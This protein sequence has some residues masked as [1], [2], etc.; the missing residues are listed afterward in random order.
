MRALLINR[1]S[2]DPWPL[3][4]FLSPHLRVGGC[5]LGRKEAAW[6]PALRGWNQSP[7][8]KPP[9]LHPP[10]CQP[11]PAQLLRSPPTFLPTLTAPC[12]VTWSP[13]PSFIGT[14]WGSCQLLSPPAPQ[15]L[16][17]YAFCTL[18]A[19]ALAQP[20]RPDPGRYAQVRSPAPYDAC[21]GPTGVTLQ[22]RWLCKHRGGPLSRELSGSSSARGEVQTWIPGLLPGREEARVSSGLPS[23]CVQLAPT[24]GLFCPRFPQPRPVHSPDGHV[25]CQ[26]PSQPYS[27]TRA[28]AH[29]QRTHVLPGLPPTPQRRD[30]ARPG[31]QTIPKFY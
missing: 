10:G 15:H 26:P 23:S 1:P 19:S 13:A 8:P 12:P 16:T 29:T 14:L 25:L 2:S 18:N 6:E 17:L 4:S 28:W 3:L 31:L 20:P 7:V 5:G 24:T 30:L 11:G 22:A 9:P 27:D 21:P